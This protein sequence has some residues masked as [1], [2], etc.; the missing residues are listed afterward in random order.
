MRQTASLY[1]PIGLLTP[2]T[3]Q[4]KLLMRESIFEQRLIVNISSKDIWDIPIS[5]S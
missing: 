1:D 4:A 3:L 2:I 5:H